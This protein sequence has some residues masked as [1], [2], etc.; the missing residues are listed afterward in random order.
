M[1]E[2]KSL[3]GNEASPNSTV[4]TGLII[5]IKRSLCQRTLMHL[6]IH[7]ILDEHLAVKKSCSST[8]TQFDNR[9]KKVRVY[10][11]T[12]MLENYERGASKDL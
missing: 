4:K 12:E 11:C 7:S 10:W 3:Y 9:S 2:L 8:P 5:S 6:C 1:D